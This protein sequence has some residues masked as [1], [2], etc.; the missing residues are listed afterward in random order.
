LSVTAI[1][2]VLAP[3]GT[4]RLV[5]AFELHRRDG[6]CRTAQRAL[7]YRSAGLGNNR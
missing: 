4:D 1:A 5:P 3:A 7:E 6:E 2:K